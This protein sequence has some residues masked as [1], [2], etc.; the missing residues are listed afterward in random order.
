MPKILFFQPTVDDCLAQIEEELSVDTANIVLTSKNEFSKELKK[1][2][3][4]AWSFLILNEAASKFSLRTNQVKAV[5]EGDVL[6]INEF[7]AES[8]SLELMKHLDCPNIT[9]L[10]PITEHYYKN[11]PLFLVSIPKSGTHLLYKLV[12]LM[13]YAAGVVHNNNPLPGNWYCVEYS[14]SH[15]TAKDFFIDSVRKAPFG[16][17][18]HPFP[19]T[20]T[21]F[22]YRNPL[23]IL[24]SEANYYHLEDATVFSSYLRH[25]N[26]EERL[27]R[28]IFD[29]NLLGTIR[30]RINNFVPWFD[31]EN[32]ISLSFEELVGARGG[33]DD[34]MM[35]RLIWSIQLKL[36]V[37]GDPEN[38]AENL[39]DRS[40]P[41]FKEGKIGSSRTKLTVKA[42]KEFFELNQ[43]FMYETG[44]LDKSVSLD[45]TQSILEK[46][47]KISSRA[48]QCL[49]KPLQIRKILFEDTSFN[50]E[51]MYIGHNIV[52]LAERYYAIP[53]DAGPV[54]LLQLRQ[55]NQLDTLLSASSLQSLKA[56]VVSK[57]LRVVAYT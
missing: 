55:D 19:V 38:I 35:H 53:C 51:W 2:A 14:N 32:V 30:D 23:D 11:R 54:D 9:I 15:T 10:A 29:P 44:Y 52:K 27:S 7:S 48:E 50:V 5:K 36:H 1:K 4:D 43:D 8:L 20:P 33:G 45:E 40:S 28:L 37:P 16:N 12:E 24:I 47:N 41:T 6:I 57:S 13:G 39:F 56:K 49:T 34:D 42:M 25:L 18:A 3:R 31:F 17:K 26:F 21:L 46:V 22:I